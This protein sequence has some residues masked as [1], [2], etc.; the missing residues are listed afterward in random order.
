MW[1]DEEIQ[2]LFKNP[3]MSLADLALELGKT[4]DAV[5]TKRSRLGIKREQMKPWTAD[6]RRILQL[7]YSKVPKEELLELLPG[8]TWNSISSQVYYLRRRQWNI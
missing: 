4:V 3:T 8:R 5:K 7:N 2:F 1:T 6:E